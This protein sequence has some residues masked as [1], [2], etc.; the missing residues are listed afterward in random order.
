M[1]GIKNK[2][3][4]QE[5]ITDIRSFDIT[6]IKLQLMTGFVVIIVITETKTI[7]LLQKLQEVSE[8]LCVVIRW[9]DGLFQI[10]NFKQAKN[11]AS[12]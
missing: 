2:Q 12:F 3:L 9:S 10:L 11:R 7:A 5:I 8:L 1:I 4:L 6:M